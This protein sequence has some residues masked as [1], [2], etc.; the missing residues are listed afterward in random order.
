[1][2][3]ILEDVKYNLNIE[4]F[5]ELIFHY[6]FRSGYITKIPKVNRYKLPARE[7]EKL[8][9]KYVMPVWMST[10]YTDKPKFQD[11]VKE[12][13]F[14]AYKADEIDKKMTAALQYATIKFSTLGEEAFRIILSDAI[15]NS[16]TAIPK[17]DVEISSGTRIH[18]VCYY[19]GCVLV[20][21]LKFSNDKPD[22]KAEEAIMQIY[23][24]NYMHKPLKLI[25]SD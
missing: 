6:L 3:E 7:V 2:Y 21:E 1:M 4:S 20:Y 14:S 24:Q 23:S 22:G 19:Y 15:E 25:K 16:A 18:L 10:I 8:Y 12:I 9:T 13:D 17:R 5:E 11:I